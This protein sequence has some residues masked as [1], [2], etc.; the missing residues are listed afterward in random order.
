MTTRNIEK[1]EKRKTQIVQAAFEVIASRGYNSFTIEDIANRAGLSKGGV[2]HYFKTKEDILIHLLEMIYRQI[3]DTILRRSQRYRTAEKKL[4][5]III[6]FIVTAK[7]R[8][9]VYTVM[10]DF[11]AQVPTNDRVRNINGKI[12]GII[13]DEVKKIIDLGIENGEF[14]AVDSASVARLIV[15][16]VMNVA[17]QWTFNDKAY[18]IDHITRAC[19]SMV[20]TYLKKRRDFKAE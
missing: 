7:R 6:A 18:N 15:S 20:T 11:W 1:E 14:A 19:L 3:K 2:L 17:I 8:P 13:C 10:V 12:Y 5:A 16:M 9:S 4:K